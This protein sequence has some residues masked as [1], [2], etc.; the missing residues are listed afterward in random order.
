MTKCPKS[1]KLEIMCPRKRLLI[2]CHSFDAVFS[3]GITTYI[4]GIYSLLP[5]IN[6]NIDFFFVACDIEKIRMLFGTGE[7][8]H[9]IRLTAKNKIYRLFF[10]L[11]E[12]IRKYDIDIAHFQYVSPLIKNCKTIVT[13][14]DIL[15]IDYPQYFP[16]TYKLSKALP[17]KLSA[18]RA[19]L[20]CTVSN[21]SRE[22]ISLHYGIDKNK[23]IITP[24]AVDKEFYEIKGDRPEGFPDKYILYVS[25]IEP[26][27]NHLEAVKSFIRLELYKQ[28]FSLVL[29]GRETVPTPELHNYI[30][31]LP[32]DVRA[33]IKLISQASFH[34]LKLWYKYAELFI[35]PSLAEGFGI[36]PIEAAASGIPVI[37][38][39][40]TAMSEFTFL[41]ENLIDFEN[42]EEIDRAIILN[43][44][45]HYSYKP[46][47]IREKIRSKYNWD[48]IA[49]QLNKAINERFF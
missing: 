41:G 34:E 29:I 6:K 44:E 40:K 39:K 19:D 35:Y 30:N 45:G 24:N 7:N 48:N 9:Y 36:P 26:R 18:R 21:Y 43:I 4:K 10:E 37:S 12:I 31:Q 13:L 49:L 15:F 17:F 27:K 25:R 47:D 28:D 1:D 11:P 42:K 33:K 32:I 8:I 5:K 20:L 16:T 14:H 22:Q 3:Q 38:H 46:Q 2:D 23:I